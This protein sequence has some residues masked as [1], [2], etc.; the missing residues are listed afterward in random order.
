MGAPGAGD[1]GAKKRLSFAQVASQPPRV[2][3]TVGGP[4]PARSRGP[5]G[6]G[7]GYSPAEFP[8]IVEEVGRGF[9]ALTP[10]E[11]ERL[12]TQAVKGFRGSL[13]RLPS[14]GWLVA[15]LDQETQDRVFKLKNLPGGIQVQTRRP[16]PVV[17]GVIR[18]IAVGPGVEDRVRGDLRAQGLWVDRVTCLDLADGTPSRSLRVSFHERKLPQSVLLGSEEFL[19]TPFVPSVRRCTRC[20][21]FGH[22]RRNCRRKHTKCA[23]CGGDGHAAPDCRSDGLRCCNCGGGHSAAWAGCPES[24]IRRRA[25]EIR[26]GQYMPFFQAIKLAKEVPSGPLRGGLGEGPPAHRR[27]KGIEKY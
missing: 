1:C 20:Q 15:C 16:D 27:D 23:R 8:V 2:A 10:W 18:G 17:V 9:S 21:A 24:S 26:S 19:V 12:L 3:P 5:V 11:R 14:G 4:G 22:L 7:G 13:R 25:G 6:T